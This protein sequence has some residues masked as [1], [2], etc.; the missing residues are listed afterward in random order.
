MYFLNTADKMNGDVSNKDI[1]QAIAELSQKFD[2]F[3]RNIITL[4]ENKVPQNEKD[5]LEKVA[6]NEEIDSE[7]L[8]SEDI[9]GVSNGAKIDVFE[10]QV[11]SNE[12]AISR[13]LLLVDRQDRKIASSYFLCAS[14]G[15]FGRAEF[16]YPIYCIIVRNPRTNKGNKR[17]MSPIAGKFWFSEDKFDYFK[18]FKESTQ[19]L[20]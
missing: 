2:A 5:V 3:D 4:V 12:T 8:W 1:L 10:V 9:N 13:L 15:A 11:I 19:R 20:S 6:E 17:R 14:I 16:R 7:T 18:P